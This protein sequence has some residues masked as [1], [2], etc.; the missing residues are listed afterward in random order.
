MPH[1]VVVG[2]LNMDLVVRT[3]RMPGP[4][5]TV[6]GDD[7]QTIPGGKGANQAVAAAR[8]GARVSMVGRVGDDAFGQTLRSSLQAEGIDISHVK[9]DS[10]APT[11]IAMITLD[12]AGQN[13]IVVAPGA[14]A[15]LT[16]E[17]VETALNAAGAFDALVMQLE[18]SLPAVQAATRMAHEHGA[19]IILN[20][21]P[22]QPVPAELL[23]LVDVLIPNESETSMLSGLPADSPEQAEE[24]AQVLLDQ[25]VGAV[26]LTLGAHGA[27]VLEPGQ[28]VVHLPPYLV[29]VVDTTAAGDAF[30]AALATRWSEGVSLWEAAYCG[31]KAGALAVTK[32]GAQPSLP[33]WAELEQLC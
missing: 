23:T 3:H 2:S 12:E 7:F 5:E 32:L 26:V 6:L 28:E 17:D 9:V 10:T 22:A 21:A 25:G 15:Q 18:T 14:N 13:S 33:T 29:D 31:N 27:V 30:V 24:A 19:K 20:P 16:A 1:I 8:Q 4:G 11:G